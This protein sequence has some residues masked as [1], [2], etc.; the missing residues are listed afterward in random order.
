MAVEGSGDPNL[1]RHS[2]FRDDGRVALKQH[3]A[4]EKS[5]L[6]YEGYDDDDDLP[7]SVR[8]SRLSNLGTPSSNFDAGSVKKRRT[9][10]PFLCTLVNKSKS[11]F[12]SYDDED[13]VPLSQRIKRSAA[14]PP[15]SAP[16]ISKFTSTLE[17]QKE[18]QV[19]E[20]EQ[21]KRDIQ[22]FAKELEN[23]KN[24][25]ACVRRINRTNEKIQRKIEECYK[26]LVTKE[27]Q[28][29]LM[30]GMVRERDLELKIEEIELHQ[31]MDKIDE[32]RERKKEELKALFQEK[33]ECTKKL[34]CI[35]RN[36]QDHKK[37][38]SKIEECVKDLVVTL[39]GLMEDMFTEHRLGLESKEVEL[40]QVKG[41]IYKD[42]D[43]RKIEEAKALHLKVKTQEKELDSIKKLID[44]QAKELD[45]ERK[46]LHKV[47][48]TKADQHAQI[49]DFDLT[50]KQFEE[51][52]NEHESKEKHYERRVKEL[53]SKEKH[54]E[55]RVK[56]LKSK[57]KHLEGGVMEFELKE[58]EFE[59]QVKEIELKKK[60]FESQVKE[61]ESKEKQFE[62]RVKELESKEEEFEGHLKE[63]ELRKEHFESHAKELKSKEDQLKGRVKE[64]ESKEKEFESKEEEFEVQMK[65]LKLKKGHF[66]SQVME[67][68]SKEN[69][70]KGHVREFES[71]EEEF[72]RQVKEIELKKK[73]FESQVKELE[74]TEKQYEVWVKELE[75]KEEEFEGLLKECELKQKHFESRVKELESKEN[76]L[77]GRVKEFESKE[78]EFENQMKELQLKKE[79]F[80]SQ[81]NELKSKEKQLKGRLREFEYK[82]EEFE[83]QIKEFESKE[84]EFVKQVKDL[85]LKKEE[86]E[87]Q[88]K[89]LESKEKQFEG[90]GKELESKDIKF[91]VQAKE[92]MSKE[93]Q[94]QFK[95]LEFKEKQFEAQLMELKLKEKRFK[96]QVKDLESKRDEFDEQLKELDLIQ[97]Q[98]EA[99]IKSFE[100]EKELDNQ[101]SPT[102]SED[103]SESLDNE[104]LIDLKATSDPS[105]V[106]LDIIQKPIIPH[107]KD[108]DD[109]V[110]MDSR[111][112]FLLKQLLRISP[113]IKPYVREEAMKLALDLK[114]NMRPSTKNSL[115]VLGFLLLLSIYGLVPSF[116]ENEVLKL[117]EFAA[118]HKQAV[119]LFQ[120]LGFADKISDFVRN[121]INK[122]QYI[123]AVRFICAYKLVDNNQP[124]DLLREYVQNAKLISEISCKNT[125]SLEIKDKVR[126]QEMA[127]LTN[128]LE[129]ISDNNL[130]SGDLINEIEDRILELSKQ[131]VSSVCTRTRSI[132]QKCNNLKERNV[133]TKTC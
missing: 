85:E 68:K 131:K 44:Q 34:G 95:E 106:V 78:E 30:N 88:V 133:V 123:E 58:K 98:Y 84:E 117:F 24:H 132:I 118:Q 54:V 50:K 92:L 22:E 29:S 71:K 18:K 103:E 27:A 79:H 110:I 100:E 11:N 35:R 111:H 60:H 101:L 31:V 61:L 51:Q 52:I 47:M 33:I 17:G 130:E 65:E 4:Y 45:S 13:D 32:D 94:G 126:D 55:E 3:N 36:N 64:F 62:G 93:K 56:K 20:Q 119:E 96:A 46:K 81:V 108:G 42:H 7:L 8:V 116:D 127:T 128:V 76:Q 43:E 2:D 105:K 87:G 113:H 37:M 112:V 86:F 26:D 74:S 102:M 104:I 122:Q 82:E 25:V 73:H 83:D 70:L 14:S 39:F 6:H 107:F 124:V 129:C 66:E 19:E 72:A 114:A 80:E 75:S 9:K 21:K 15:K 77:E 69:E 109:A 120:T 99:L 38:L 53:K 89:E 63:Y 48:P 1:L 23:K 125:N 41:D 59:R 115:E 67:L 57:E 28:L 40:H 5:Q 121:L 91:E 97:K 10:R 12:S 90:R 49:K 16:D